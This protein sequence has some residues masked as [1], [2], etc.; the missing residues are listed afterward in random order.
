VSRFIFAPNFSTAAAVTNVSGRGVG[1]DIVR[2]NIESIGGT[3]SLTTTPGKGSR[4]A[5]RIP[6]TL[7]IAPALIVEVGRHRFALPQHSV[8]EAV[9]LDT[10]GGAHKLERVQGSLV[11]RLRDEVL[12][13]TDLAELLGLE[14]ADPTVPPGLAM[15]M[16]FG[17]LAFG[18]LVDGVADVQEIVV[19]PLGASLSDIPQFSG[20]TILGDG[21]VV[22]ILDPSGIAHGLGLEEM[23]EHAMLRPPETFIPT[24][25]T[26]RLVLFRAGPGVLKAIP[27]SLIA[28][29]ETVDVA[30]IAQSAGE[31]VMQHQGRLMPLVPVSPGSTMGSHEQ[32]ILVLSIGG[33]SMGL[34]IDEIVDIVE[35]KLDI[36]IAGAADRIVGTAQVR[37]QVVEILDVA[38]FMRLGRPKAFARAVVKRFTVLLVDDKLFFR[39]MLSPI[40]KAAGYNLVTAASA[41]DALAM[42]ERGAQFQ[43]IVT[44]TDMPGMS[45]YELA[46]TLNA[47]SRW[48]HIPIVA[49]AAH[50]APAVA[51][52]A[53]ACGMRAA[54]G[55]FDRAGLLQV[56]GRVLDSQELSEH[57]LERRVMQGRAA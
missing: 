8:V 46:R 56:M 25:E 29:I 21:S 23:S 6:L 24:G 4:F 41:E 13:V 52:A 10:K 32:P 39:D 14:R 12:P 5:L 47:D 36:E 54:V 16:R 38:H 11:L 2:D 17:A 28:R 7:A 30:D 43:A 48:S 31:L 51:Q 42:L 22:L 1:M 33:E 20:H 27:L 34:L 57:D 26:T 18:I 53:A 49:L 45:G 35:E 40:L 55:K 15:V 50:A 44:D 3:V 9:G 19:K 37:D